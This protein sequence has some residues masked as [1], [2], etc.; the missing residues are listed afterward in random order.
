MKKTLLN[1]LLL[2]IMLPAL[3]Q[4][5]IKKPLPEKLVVLTFDDAPVTHYSY[6]APLL[7]QYGFGATFF[8][9]E[10]PPNYNDTSKYMTWQQM[11]Q[12]DKMGFEVA[13]HTHT[14]THVNRINKAQLHEQLQYI[15]N[16]CSSFKIGHPISFAYPG[17]SLSDTALQVLQERNYLFARAGGGRPY[18]PLADHPYLIPSWA[19]TDKNKEQIMQALQQAKKGKIIVLTIH[20][21][22][23]YEHPWVTTP[24]ELFKEYLQYLNDNQYT[25]IALK[26]LQQYINV[27]KAIQ[28]L[29]PDFTKPLKN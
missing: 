10:F 14:H 11:Q 21:V 28:V 23:D 18:D 25:V 4:H 19:T 3:A 6:V 22:P 13:N 8:V 1:I 24:P 16:K 5:I 26:D 15:E 7:Q 20:G 17:Y 2:V 29:Q 27:K 9:C 12:L